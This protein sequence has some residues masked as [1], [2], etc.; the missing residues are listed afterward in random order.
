M[1]MK[2]QHRDQAFHTFMSTNNTYPL[3]LHKNVEMTMV[4]S[5][6]INITIHQKD[7]VLSEGDI[8]IIFPN[9]PH[10][11]NTTDNNRILLIFFDATFPGDFT[12]DLL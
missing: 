6:K 9:Q 3:H 5:G 12:G 2:Y 10:S 4:L 11:Y 7:F 8:G 1:N